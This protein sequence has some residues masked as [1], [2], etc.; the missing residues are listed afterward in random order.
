MERLRLFDNPVS[1]AVILVLCQRSSQHLLK[2]AD[3]TETGHDTSVT[4]ISL[5]CWLIFDASD[6]YSRMPESY[7]YAILQHER[8]L[9][10]E[11]CSHTSPEETMAR[12][13]RKTRLRTKAQEPPG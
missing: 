8:C 1:H 7:H 6:I 5:Y 11:A 4:N 3:G 13:R 9:E 2:I 12:G 10:P